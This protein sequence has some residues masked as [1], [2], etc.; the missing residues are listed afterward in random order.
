MN[1]DLYQVIDQYK[2]CDGILTMVLEE[3]N[4]EFKQRLKTNVFSVV[5][6]MMRL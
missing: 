6:W 3:V 5:D 2:I 4:V 1:S